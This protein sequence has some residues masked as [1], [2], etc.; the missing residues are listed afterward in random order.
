MI[1][2]L[3]DAVTEA[4]L[5]ANGVAFDAIRKAPDVVLITIWP[6]LRPVTGS[7]GNRLGIAANAV[8]SICAPGSSV[9]VSEATSMISGAASLAWPPISTAAADGVMVI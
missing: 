9:I 6:R 1:S 2:E 5:T 7:V 8:V 3:V 4:R